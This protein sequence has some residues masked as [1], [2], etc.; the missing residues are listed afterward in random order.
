MT[1]DRVSGCAPEFQQ[2][3]YLPLHFCDLVLSFHYRAVIGIGQV[4]G[5]FPDGPKGWCNNPP[6]DVEG[7]HYGR[8]WDVQFG[9]RC[10]QALSEHRF[11]E[12]GDIYNDIL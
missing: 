2:I 6:R 9:T 11:L 1:H 10:S 7:E 8:L 4:K 12:Q 5:Q 3:C